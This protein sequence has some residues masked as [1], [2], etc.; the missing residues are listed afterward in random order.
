MSLRTKLFA[1][2]VGGLIAGYL[3]VAFVTLEIDFRNWTDS[4]RAGLFFA[5][6]PLT[7]VLAVFVFI[8]HE[9]QEHKTRPKCKTAIGSKTY[10]YDP[11]T[12]KVYTPENQGGEP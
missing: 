11:L 9:E 2:I 4:A 7:S 10:I 6:L 3:M 12:G 8:R 5:H 1:L